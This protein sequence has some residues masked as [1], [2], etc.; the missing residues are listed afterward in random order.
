M[1]NIIYALE[2]SIDQKTTVGH[3]TQLLEW[4]QS[5]AL[6]PERGGGGGQQEFSLVAGGNAK[7]GGHSGRQTVWWRMTNPDLLL[8][9]DPAAE[10]LGVYPKELKTRP[11][12]NLHVNVYSR[13]IYNYSEATERS[14]SRCLGPDQSK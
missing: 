9:Y 1:P 4:P 10:L 5:R 13:F 6:R 12:N 7:W 8:Q 3:T 2:K 11:H 14:S